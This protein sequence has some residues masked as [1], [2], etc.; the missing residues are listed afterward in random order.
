MFLLFKTKTSSIS[1]KEVISSNFQEIREVLEEFES[2]S[3]E[4]IVKIV[5]K[6]EF[7]SFSDVS[8]K[9]GVG[10]NIYHIINQL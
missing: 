8:H 10:K 5:D 6:E 1:S 4:L 7:S 9:Y 3:E 2:L